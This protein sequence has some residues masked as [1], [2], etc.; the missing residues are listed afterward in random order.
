MGEIPTASN[1]LVNCLSKRSRDWITYGER[2]GYRNEAGYRLAVDAIG[3]ARYLQSEGIHYSGYPQDYFED[4][5]RRCQP[6]PRDRD[7]DGMWLTWQSAHRRRTS[8]SCPPIR[9]PK[10]SIGGLVQ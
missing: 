1:S 8:P 5:L 3:T 7:L 4:F 10:S 6:S 2:E 9:S